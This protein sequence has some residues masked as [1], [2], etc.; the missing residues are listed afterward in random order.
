VDRVRAVT[1]LSVNFDDAR[2]A[3]EII[4]EE[5]ASR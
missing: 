4:K 2:R 3:I 5:L 1:H